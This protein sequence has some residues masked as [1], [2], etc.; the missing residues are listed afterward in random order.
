MGDCAAKQNPPENN[1]PEFRVMTKNMPEILLPYNPYYKVS[2][3]D[4]LR[5]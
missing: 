5:P 1:L 2:V 3:H 4:V